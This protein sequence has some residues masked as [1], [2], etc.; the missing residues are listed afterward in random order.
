MRLQE[1]GKLL[2]HRH[3]KAETRSLSLRLT[4]PLESLQRGMRI[5]APHHAPISFRARIQMV[6]RTTTNSSSGKVPDSIPQRLRRRRT[7][8]LATHREISEMFAPLQISTKTS[9]SRNEFP[10]IRIN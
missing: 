10:C 8:R 4:G 9:T 6:S 7:L 5:S 1:A 2:A 3:T